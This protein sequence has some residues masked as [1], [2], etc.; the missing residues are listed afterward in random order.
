M[1][2]VRSSHTIPN[3]M[4]PLLS[5][6]LHRCGWYGGKSLPWGRRRGARGRRGQAWV[7]LE[8]PTASLIEAL[9]TLTG[10]SRG[11]LLSQGSTPGPPSLGFWPSG[12]R[13]PFRGSW[14]LSS[15]LPHLSPPLLPEAS[16]PLPLAKALSPE[17][18]HLT[19]I[20]VHVLAHTGFAG[21]PTMKSEAPPPDGHTF[22]FAV[23]L[24]DALS[25]LPTVSHH[26]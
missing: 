22:A 16:A 19:N 2:P 14:M 10:T 15:L 1:T 26:P 24:P 13:Q 21:G 3:K 4:S 9:C 11:S 8:A 7:S 18:L 5:S 25:T 12:S 23:P 6:V 17:L 20:F